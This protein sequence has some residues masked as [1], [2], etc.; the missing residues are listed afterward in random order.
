ML[1]GTTARDLLADRRREPRTILCLIRH[2]RTE[3]NATG[4][5]LGRTDVP[6][7]AVGRAQAEALARTLRG[8]FDVAYS[9]PLLRARQ[10][11]SALTDTVQVEPDLIEL[12][13]GVL[14]GLDGPTAVRDHPDFFVR[15]SQDPA[16]A[17]LPGGERFDELQERAVAAL[18]SIARRHPTG[19][20]IGVFTHQMVIAAVAC[21][22]LGEPLRRWREHRVGNGALSL[23]LP[24]D[25]ALD[26]L[27]HGVQLV[28]EVAD[29]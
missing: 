29:G 14:E 27:A 18:R 24:T 17:R 28:G 10:T 25:D 22:A 5:F 21:A 4:R 20:R 16:T 23:V 11:A 26:L 3:W 6:L 15:W 12:H 9:S 19:A 1:D 13:Q 2:G 7:D 8:S